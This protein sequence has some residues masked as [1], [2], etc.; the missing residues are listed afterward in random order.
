[1][2]CVSPRGI[3][4]SLV[5][6]VRGYTYHGDTHITVTAAVGKEGGTLWSQFTDY[7]SE[8]TTNDGQRV[9]F[10]VSLFEIVTNYA[11]LMKQD[12]FTLHHWAEPSIDLVQAKKVARESHLFE[13][14]HTPDL[15]FLQG[16]RGTQW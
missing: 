9:Q 2:F 3:H 8:H 14:L 16:G 10:R 4:I 15:P 5:I 12:H 13:T 1:M 6:C 11:H 7:G